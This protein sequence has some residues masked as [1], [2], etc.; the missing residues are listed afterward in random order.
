MLNEP[1]PSGGSQLPPGEH[2]TDSF[3]SASRPPESGGQRDRDVVEIAREEVPKLHSDQGS[4]GNLPSRAPSGRA[5]LLTQEGVA[6]PKGLAMAF[7]LLV[8]V[9]ALHAAQTPS[10]IPTVLLPSTS[11]LVTFRILFNT[12]SA[13][14]PPGKEG[15]AALTAAMVT[16]GGTASMTSEQIQAALYPTSASISAQVDKEMTVFTASTHRETLDRVYAALQGMLLDPGF[17]EE[18]FKRIRDNT[19]NFLK[20]SLRERDDEELG[21]EYLYN[22]IYAGTPYAHHSRGRISS[23]EK[24]TLNDVRTFYRTNYT[25]GNVTLGLAGGYPQTFPQ[26]VL[27]DLNKLPTT[28][29]TL[30]R[31]DPQK[32]ASGLRL[33]IIKRETDATAISLGFPISVTRADKDWPALLVA[34]SYL[35]QHRSSNGRLFNRLREQRGLNYGD[36]AYV[37]YFPQGGGQFTP[38]PNIARHQQIFQIWI[39]PVEPRNGLFALRAALYEYDKFVREGLSRQAFEATRSFLTKYSGV[40]TQTQTALLGYA[41]DSRFY[42]IPNYNEHV[43]EQLSKLNVDDVNRAIRTHLKTDSMRVVVVTKDAAGLRDVIVSGAVSPITYN[44]PKPK[45][46]LDEDKIIQVFKIDVQPENVVVRPVDEL[47]Q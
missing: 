9:I 6:L 18:D 20:T 23:V 16:Q 24:L 46:I 25:T 14:D 45:E 11:P 21:K 40:L 31:F 37:E 7:L 32:P 4:F 35:G 38:P 30:W 12:G 44:S 33:E 42:G 47:F 27:T 22:I 8:S 13:Y 19:L 5:A 29:G 26:R 15:L 41:L 2:E 34:A 17:R 36:Y 3:R 10:R 1:K 39:R 28:A 43:R